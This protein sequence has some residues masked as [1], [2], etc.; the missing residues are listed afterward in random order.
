[1]DKSLQVILQTFEGK[2]EEIIPILQNV[3]D[4]YSYIPE[5]SMTDIALFTGVPESQ[6]YGVATF[7]AQFRFTPRGKKHC[8]V[9]RGTACHV[10]GAPR[11]LEEMEE[12]LGIKQGETSEDLEY[13]LETVA[14]IGAC[15]LAPAIMVNDTV[16]AKLDPKKVR[17]LFGRVVANE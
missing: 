12:A 6:V 17:K 5:R 7:Y 3:Q 2:K 13:S 10:N 11:I 1:M 4:A 16:E 8:M 14:C 15:S 9:C